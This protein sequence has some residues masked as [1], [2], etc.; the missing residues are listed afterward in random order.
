MHNRSDIWG[1]HFGAYW[2]SSHEQLLYHHGKTLS[3]STKVYYLLLALVENSDHILSKDEIIE[4]VWPDQVV[5]DTALAKQVLRLRQVLRDQDRK[6]PF[7]ETHRG[8]GYR[9]TPQ[10]DIVEAETAPFSSR[11]EPARRSWPTWA[12]VALVL[13][14]V[15]LVSTRLQTPE[16]SPNLSPDADQPVSLA[17]LQ[18]GNNSDWLSFGGVEYLS[19][20]LGGDKLVYTVNPNN[21]W[22]SAQSN[23]Q[24]AVE[25][26][27]YE[28]IQYTCLLDITQVDNRFQ[29]VANLRSKDGLLA[30][31][32][33]DAEELPQVFE[34][35]DRWIRSHLKTA[36][37]GTALPRPAPTSNESALQSYFQGL[38][39]LYSEGDHQKAADF[40][41]AAITSDPE[42]LMARAKLA[43]SLTELGDQNE[44]LSIGLTLLERPE[45]EEN[46]ALKVE[47]HAVVARAY[48][49]MRDDE[50]AARF[51]RRT[52]EV[53]ASTDNPYIR[54]DGLES[55]GMLAR[56][57]GGAESAEAFGLERL[58]LAKKYYPV[59]NYL[60]SIHLQLASFFEQG[61]QP[62]K[63]REHAE[64]AIRLSEQG[65]NPNG[66]IA[67][68]R[69]L[70][71]YNMAVNRLDDGVKAAVQAEPFLDQSAASYDKA[72]F[73][74]FSAM[75]LNLRGRFELAESYSSMLKSLAAQS[76]NALYEVLADFTIL[77]RFYVQDRLNDARAY[78]QSM[79]ARFQNDALMRSALPD[80]MV[81]EATVS[82]RIDDVQQATALLAELEEKYGSA[83]HRLGN[84]LNRVKGHVAIRQGRVEEGL[85]LLTEAEQAIRDKMQQAVANYI[86]YEILQVMLEHPQLEYQSVIDRLDRNTEY[87]YH[88]HRLKAQFKAREG[89]Y[90][91]AAILM[92]ENRLRANLLWK[93]E[94][95]LLLESYLRK[96]NA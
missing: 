91:D 28:P 69:Y 94:D 66:M 1:Y 12:A 62:N 47:V 39:V 58:E 59:P 60:A 33:I 64:A 87:D 85:A 42:F 10:V 8:V 40:F 79:R 34:E 92:Q 13:L 53:I 70:N 16:L 48:T 43:R 26:T 32:Q 51:L 88:F 36:T 89:E 18:M 68:Y 15:Y 20:L 71:G 67:G 55:L 25:L 74:Q 95:Q 19:D 27:G 31:R 90:L 11:P 17:V 75:I 61:L 21:R 4:S 30:S 22:S 7:I 41:R 78:A 96:A 6:R 77:H 37:D 5:T 65:Q 9:F 81:I 35:T 93:P 84:D 44:A 38:Q 63:L 24:W 29:V 2:L 45:V 46:D 73:L 82:A 50:N 76:N 52:R 14:G 83:T 72:F 3:L 56:M 49:R 57:E 54:L 86:G 23:E 80:A